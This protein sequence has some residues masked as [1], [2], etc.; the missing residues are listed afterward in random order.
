MLAPRAATTAILV[1]GLTLTAAA[2]PSAVL[3]E[4]PPFFAPQFHFSYGGPAIVPDDQRPECRPISEAEAYFDAVRNG[5]PARGIPG[6]TIVLRD[7]SLDAGRF[8]VAA[9][10]NDS[11]LPFAGNYADVDLVVVRTRPDLAGFANVHFGSRKK[12]IV[13]NFAH[14]VIVTADRMGIGLGGISP[15]KAWPEGDPMPG[16]SPDERDTFK[17]LFGLRNQL[18]RGNA[19]ERAEA[20]R[21]L[22]QLMNNPGSRLDSPFPPDIAFPAPPKPRPQFEPTPKDVESDLSGRP[23]C[24]DQPY[25]RNCIPR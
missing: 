18:E 10:S 7:G 25:V 9:W 15:K 5:A 1:L 13:C 24:R 19:E 14:P 23:F 20:Q 2:E 17:M 3:R 6:E 8:I 4:T 12:G 21:G 22:E 16:M 11:V